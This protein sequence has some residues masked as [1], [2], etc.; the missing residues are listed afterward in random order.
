MLY[1]KIVI[2][3]FYSFILMTFLASLE[4]YFEIGKFL[5]LLFLSFFENL[6]DARTL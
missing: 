6:T 5:K 3:I 1:S 2:V 4:S